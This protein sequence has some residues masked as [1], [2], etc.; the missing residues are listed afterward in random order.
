MLK[1]SMDSE[2][3]WSKPWRKTHQEVL[4][5]KRDRCFRSCQGH[6][7]LRPTRT[8]QRSAGLH[9]PCSHA[10][11]Y[12]GAAGGRR[13]AELD[14]PCRGSPPPRPRCLQ[15]VGTSFCSGLWGGGQEDLSSRGGEASDRS[16][17]QLQHARGW[18]LGGFQTA[19]WDSGCTP[20]G[21]AEFPEKKL[22]ENRTLCKGKAAY[23][24]IVI[25]WL[26]N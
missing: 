1:V 24:C 25:S 7:P 4:N 3:V 21:S 19:P 2:S 26:H 14:R 15:G 9:L 23:I 10:A 13:R 16:R 22:K 20:T 11:S 6:K 18:R 8:Y 17:R 5:N 12:A